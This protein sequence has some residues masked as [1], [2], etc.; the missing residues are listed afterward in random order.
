MSVVAVIKK[1]VLGVSIVVLVGMLSGISPAL[2][3][4]PWWHLTSGSRPANLFHAGSA[5]DEVQE[6]AVSGTEGRFALAGNSGIAF[7]EWDAED[8][9]SVV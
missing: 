5:T 3:S 9:K 6:V 4:S 7:F 8:R 1:S 2:A